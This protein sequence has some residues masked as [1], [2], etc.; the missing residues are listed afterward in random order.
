MSN[1]NRGGETE[2]YW[3]A[4]CSEHGFLEGALPSEYDAH[5]VLDDHRDAGCDG[6]L[7]VVTEEQ[8]EQI[9][10]AGGSVGDL[11]GPAFSTEGP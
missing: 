6:R 3:L 11:G 2:P 5:G 4:F 9:K 8:W 7:R 10:L 1:K